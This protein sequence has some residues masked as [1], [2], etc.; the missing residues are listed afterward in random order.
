MRKPIFCKN[1]CA[2]SMIVTT[3]IWLLLISQA[4]AQHRNVSRAGYDPTSKR[5]IFIS[6]MNQSKNN[7]E[8]SIA[9]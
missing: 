4:T 2:G 7:T 9:F 5:R 6:C 3:I 1:L 8:V